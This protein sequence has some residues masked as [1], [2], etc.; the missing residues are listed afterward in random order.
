MK[1]VLMISTDRKAF[2]MGS[3]VRKRLI[4]YGEFSA[5]LEII[6]FS[7]ARHGFR[8]VAISDKVRLYATNSRTRWGY[9]YR[10]LKLARGIGATDLVTCQDPF[11]TGLTGWLIARQSKAKLE[12]QIHTDLLSPAFAAESWLN[13]LRVKLAKFLLPRADFIRVVSER[14]KKSIIAAG[15]KLK[16][17]ITVWPI[18][19][20]ESVPDNAEGVNLRLAYPQFEKIV[21]MTVR[22]TKEKQ[23]DLA[24]KA[25]SLVLK[26]RPNLGLI[27][28][29]SG[30]LAP[31]LKFLAK[32]LKIDRQVIFTG[33]VNNLLPLYQSADCFLL[34]SA[35]EGYGLSLVEAASAGLPIVSTDVGVAAEVGAIVVPA[36]AEQIARAILLALE[37]GRGASVKNLPLITK[38]EYLA[39]LKQ[40]WQ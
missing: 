22:L 8:S 39:K 1:K 13:Y 17:E 34:T 18:F 24:L 7:L 16:G 27:L 11:E 2:E 20:E 31:S 14:I 9:I 33:W 28:A 6:I 29:G 37:Q 36:E 25:L 12:F 23:L 5:G 3:A 35:Y 10:A 19:V 15:W 40:A 32:K 26:Q 4:E 21:L 30:P 38:E